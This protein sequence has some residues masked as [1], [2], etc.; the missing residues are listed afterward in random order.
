MAALVFPSKHLLAA[1]PP[2]RFAAQILE[3]EGELTELHPGWKEPARSRQG[4][5]G[6]GIVGSK[7]ISDLAVKARV[8][9]LLQ[10]RKHL[11]DGNDWEVVVKSFVGAGGDVKLMAMP[12][13]PK[14][15]HTSES[16]A[17]ASR[18][19]MA[20]RGGEPTLE[21]IAGRLGVTLGT[22]AKLVLDAPDGAN[23]YHHARKK[24]AEKP[25]RAKK[26]K[27]TPAA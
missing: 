9:Y 19:P 20:G 10:R 2:E 21:Q 15:P 4:P 5:G 16:L 6:R 7:G 3:L 12:V 25:K 22:V 27:K 17:T 24:L 8:K 23:L 26:R 13:I 11:Y 14:H 1:L 18:T